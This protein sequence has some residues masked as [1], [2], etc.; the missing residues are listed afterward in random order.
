[1]ATRAIR[2]VDEYPTAN[3]K[4]RVDIILENYSNFSEM[5]M[6]F[7]ESLKYLIINERKSARRNAM[8]D[9]GVRV[10][11]SGTS[12]KTANAAIESVMLSQAI[13]SRNLDEELRDV[14]CPEE[15]R[16]EAEAICDMREDYELLCAQ[17]K[18]LPYQESEVLIPYL[19]GTKSLFKLAEITDCSYEAVKSRLRRAKQHIRTNTEP[20]FNRKYN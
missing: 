8:G 9:L 18:T 5:M 4:R 12:D 7:E 2:I 10:Q 13:A 16:L 1:M 11:T 20:Y 19:N 17:I 3:N 15:Y 14:E 6:G